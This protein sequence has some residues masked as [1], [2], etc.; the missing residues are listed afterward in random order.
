MID[1][2]LSPKL[3]NSQIKNFTHH[4]T[5]IEM[6]GFNITEYYEPSTS[7]SIDVTVNNLPA[8]TNSRLN[9]EKNIS[10]QYSNDTEINPSI[11]ISTDLSS[12]IPT[13]LS[14]SI[15]AITPLN[16]NLLLVIT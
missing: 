4:N 7:A 5:A 15:R 3:L 13:F 6:T 10:T 8:I 16:D 14:S 9:G 12:N 1:S 11:S 2:Q